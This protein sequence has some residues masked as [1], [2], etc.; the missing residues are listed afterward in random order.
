MQQVKL[1]LT[2]D[3]IR[4]ARGLSYRFSYLPQQVSRVAECVVS[5][6]SD[7]NVFL[8]FDV[9]SQ[10]VVVITGDV[11][12]TVTLICQRCTAMFQHP[13][14][15]A[16]CVSPVANDKQAKDLPQE[17]EPIELNESRK[18]DF[19]AMIE[20]EIILSLPVMPLHE[21]ESCEVSGANRFFGQLPE[22][23][24]SD[25]PFALLASLKK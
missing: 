8:S 3:E 5:V 6:D 12:L 23:T 14:H 2:I 24:G 21:A 19:L 9:D 4:M 17:Y 13:V 16:Y 18:V 10:S 11:A 22:E 15:A 25:N 7:I 1:P 20:D